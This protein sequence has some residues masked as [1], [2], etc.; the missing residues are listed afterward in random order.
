MELSGNGTV[1]T[2]ASVSAF[3]GIGRRS[4]SSRKQS[5]C[6]ELQNNSQ[7]IP[8]LF[9]SSPISHTS[10]ARCSHHAMK[11][12]PSP[13]GASS[14]QYAAKGSRDAYR[15]MMRIARLVCDAVAWASRDAAALRRR[16]STYT[17]ALFS[18]QYSTVQTNQD[19]EWVTY[20]RQQVV[21]DITAAH[22]KVVHLPL[23]CRAVG[24][25]AHQ[26]IDA[27]KLLLR[28]TALE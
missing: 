21:C 1:P 7:Y 4:S 2:V 12:T 20:L 9:A 10:S 6:M 18:E 3:S 14:A 22:H 28:V 26:V 17:C 25:R 15:A 11:E 23:D 19:S 27:N 16:L 8:G 24:Q 5:Q 13:R